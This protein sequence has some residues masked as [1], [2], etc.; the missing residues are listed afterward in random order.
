MKLNAALTCQSELPSPNVVG[1]GCWSVREGFG[2][3]KWVLLDSDKFPVSF[4]K[5]NILDNLQN[6][7]FEQF[8]SI[9]HEVKLES[10]VED[11]FMEIYLLRLLP[12]P[13][14]VMLSCDFLW[15]PRRN[16]IV[17][18]WSSP[19]SNAMHCESLECGPNEGQ[20]TTASTGNVIPST[21][22]GR[23]AQ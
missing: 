12:N 15:V 18:T 14:D 1:N 16:G 6:I 11:R 8:H 17:L 21:I 7:P 2:K 19:G 23:S 5:Y 9:F 4:L 22:R 20:C 13:L 3:E 10:Y